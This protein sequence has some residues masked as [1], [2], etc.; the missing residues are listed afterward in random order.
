MI[1]TNFTTAFRRFQQ[2]SSLPDST[3][4]DLSIESIFT[5]HSILIGKI[6]DSLLESEGKKF[7]FEDN[8][9]NILRFLTYYFNNCKLAETI[10][11]EQ[12]YS[13]HKQI[14]LCGN[15]GCGKTLIMK[16]FEKYLKAIKSPRQF[17][18]TSVTQIVNYFKTKGHMDLYTYNENT[19]NTFEGRP[20]SICINDLGM[21]TH[22]HY[23][24]D[25]Q[26]LVNDLLF[27]R[28][29]VFV[30]SNKD[31]HVTTNLNI[32]ELRICFDDK[33]DRL[34]DRFKFYNIINLK[35]N[36]KR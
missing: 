21:T 34:I 24:T 10:F 32:A 18:S 17:T 30:N 35:G 6:A 9:V 16:I 5:K 33:E 22:K 7:I 13:I 1:E 28:N 8:N 27:A 12:D 26:I 36:S 4:E 25:T 14:M 2:Q 3:F 29:E 19:A 11:P 23:G 31:A 15:V 20:I